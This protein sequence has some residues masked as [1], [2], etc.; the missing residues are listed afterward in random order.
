M[1][2][3][4]EHTENLDTVVDLVGA[5]DLDGASGEVYM[6]G[7]SRVAVS[8][9]V[10]GSSGVVGL[11]EKNSAESGDE[12]L[13]SSFQRSGVGLAEKNATES[14]GDV[15]D[16]GGAG[17]S[18]SSPPGSGPPNSAG[19]VYSSPRRRRARHYTIISTRYILLIALAVIVGFPI[20]ITV[21]NS[22]ISSR[23]IAARP[24][25]LFPLHPLWGDFSAAFSQAHLG[26]YLRN[27]IIVTIFIVIGEL[28]TSV[29]AGYAFA[30][31][32]FPFR[33]TLFMACI[34]TMMVP[35][36][37]TIVPNRQTIVALG[38]F[39][40]FP[41]LIVP[42]LASGVGIF[43][44]R[45]AFMG[46]PKDLHDA[47]RLDGYGHWQFLAR[48]VVPLNRPLIAAFAL[49]AFMSSWNQY[50]WPLIVTNTNSV[51]TVQIGMTELEN[52]GIN[53]FNLIFAGTLLAAL[54]IFVLL[55]VFQRQLVRGLSA[56]AL[57]G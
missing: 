54:P 37:A 1:W 28:I 51:R 41:A 20:Y 31:L 56:G 55:V 44:F 34:A 7:S 16:A 45:Q 30:Y 25:V 15:N 26:L 8:D 33:R 46:V 36:E 40:S 21:V 22:L 27:S 19:Q 13:E 48:I 52:V 18:G 35:M 5:S 38:W 50:L 23:Q 17:G 42:F 2:Q 47:A 14:G 6:V 32:K 12:R 11:A 24:P 4:V 29:L 57:K 49:Y 10:A 43:L 9:G 3:L 53:H 39:N